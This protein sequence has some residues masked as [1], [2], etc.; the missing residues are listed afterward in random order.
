MRIPIDQ[1]YSAFSNTI[2]GH[3]GRPR[4]WQ[5]DRIRPRVEQMVISILLAI[6]SPSTNTDS[7]LHDLSGPS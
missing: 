4:M 7:D 5:R 1:P 2:C 6:H 3:S